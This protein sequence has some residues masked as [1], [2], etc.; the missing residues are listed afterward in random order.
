MAGSRSPT[1]KAGFV[2]KKGDLFTDTVLTCFQATTDDGSLPETSSYHQFQV[3]LSEAAAQFGK[4]MNIS[5]QFK[6]FVEEGG[7][8]NVTEEQKKAP[9]SPWPK[10]R[11]DRNLGKYCNVLMMDALEPYSLAL[12]TR[13]LKWKP[14]EVQVMLAGVRQDLKNLD[15]HMYT[16]V[17]V[18]CERILPQV[19]LLILACRHSVCGQ[20]PPT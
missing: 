8:C 11:K 20:K 16:V 12:F 2:P 19:G 13:V 6:T 15:Y 18:S 4:V 1:S 10:D 5:P 9:L 3:K 14:A 7:F 17:Y